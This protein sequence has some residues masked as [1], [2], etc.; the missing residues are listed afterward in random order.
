MLQVVWG[1]GAGA[2]HQTI[3]LV[4]LAPESSYDQV[5]SVC[6]GV[7]GQLLGGVSLNLNS[8]WV[9]DVKVLWCSLL[10]AVLGVGASTLLRGDVVQHDRWQAVTCRVVRS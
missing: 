9:S 1:F 6:R 10:G 5:G 3:T 7:E 2:F 4:F 8:L